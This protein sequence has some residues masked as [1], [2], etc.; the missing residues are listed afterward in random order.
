MNL[1]FHMQMMQ[2]HISHANLQILLATTSVF[3][4]VTVSLRM[5]VMSN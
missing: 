2:M 3:G 1:E 5:W 4:W